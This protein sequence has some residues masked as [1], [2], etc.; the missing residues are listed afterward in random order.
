M[1]TSESNEKKDTTNAED[2]LK[3]KQSTTAVSGTQPRPQARKEPH[4]AKFKG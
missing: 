4:P 3:V 2:K 1:S